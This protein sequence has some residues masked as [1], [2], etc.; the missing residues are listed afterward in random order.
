MQ[1]KTNYT[2]S[3]GELF[4]EEYLDKLR[5]EYK[6]QFKINDLKGDNSTYRIAD[7][8]L[9]KLGF[10]VEY[11]G[12]YN[13][14]KTDRERYIFK[15]DL[16]IKNRKPTIFIYPEDLGILDYVF[17]VEVKRLFGYNIYHDRKKYLRYSLNR[18]LM[19]ILNISFYHDR[20]KYLRYSLNRYLHVG[21]PLK[22]FQAFFLYVLGVIFTSLNIGLQ[23]VFSKILGYTCFLVALAYFYK[24][25]MNFIY[26][27]NLKD[28]LGF[29]TLKNLK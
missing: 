13:N 9:P 11:F 8:Y 28:I 5:I 23:E 15:R 22:I 16:Y 24:F 18:Y 10:Y 4:I 1:K 12:M 3:K 27:V 7:F 17:H 26:S 25:L 19:N 6:V 29:V 20:K 21:N 14:S 2:P